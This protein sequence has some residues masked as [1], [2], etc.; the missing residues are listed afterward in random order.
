MTSVL[1]FVL[2][3]LFGLGVI[4]GA[5]VVLCVIAAATIESWDESNYPNWDDKE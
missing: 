3:L 1:H 2:Y 4:F 5:F